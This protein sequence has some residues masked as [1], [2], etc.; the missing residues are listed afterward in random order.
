MLVRFRPGA[1]KHV[2]DKPAAHRPNNPV[3]HRSRFQTATIP[4]SRRAALPR[5]LSYPSHLRGGWREAPGGVL[6][7]TPKL[8]PP[9]TPFASLTMCFPSPQ[10]GG[11]RRDSFARLDPRAGGIR[12]SVA[13]HPLSRR[14]KTHLRDLAAR[15]ARVLNC[16]KP[17]EHQRAWGMP[18][19][20]CTRSL[21]CKIEKHTS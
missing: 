1:P 20:R 4:A 14:T 18:G 11:I 16:V 17:S 15:S 13:L 2:R 9:C 8:P 10:G 21:A 5:F 12:D 19:A 6:T 3:A 7:R